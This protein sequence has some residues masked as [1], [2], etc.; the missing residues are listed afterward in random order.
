MSQNIPNSV[1]G[2]VA[3][4]IGDHY[5]SHSRL[6]TLFMESGAPGEPP[7]GNCEKKCTNWLKR[8][9][10][11]PAI[12]AL[13]VLGAVIQEYMDMDSTPSLFGEPL[14]TKVSEGQARINAV[15]AKNQFIYRTNGCVTKA[16]STP[17]TK[18]LEEYLKTGDF[19]SIENEFERAVEHI[20]TDPHSSITASCAII[21]ATL[22]CYI[23]SFDNLNIPNKLN[24]MALWAVVQSHL[25]LN[26]DTILADDQHKILKGLSSIIDGVGAFRSHIGSAHGRGS[27]PPSIVAAEARLAVNAAH[28]I[29]IFILEKLQAKK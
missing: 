8:C 1:I 27:N 7:E 19:S 29:V 3:S 21:E 16:G 10:E 28:T 18:T 6:N 2:A 26:A 13:E 5:Y 12:N 22:K 15:L 14:S 11:D 4:V 24:V 9:N 17:I 23:E 25:D 20:Q